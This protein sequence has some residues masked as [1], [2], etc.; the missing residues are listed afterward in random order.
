MFGGDFSREA[1]VSAFEAHAKFIKER[2]PAQR[3]LVWRPQ[4]GWEPLCK[5]APCKTVLAGGKRTSITD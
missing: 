5:C 2:V 4:D 3:L 1:C